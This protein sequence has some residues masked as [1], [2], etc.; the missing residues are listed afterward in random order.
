LRR[1]VA[2]LGSTGQ[3]G[4]DLVETLRQG[5]RFDVI[6]LSHGDADCR[7]ATRIHSVLAKFR[8]NVVINCAAFVRVDDCEDQASLA[9]EV[10][11]IGALNVARACAAIDAYCVY[12]STDYVFDG[13]KNTPYV[14]SDIPNPINVYGASKLAGEYLVRQAARRW[15]IVRVA[16]LFGKTGAR[17]KGGNF[18]EMILTKARR[19]EALKVIDDI[20]VSP[21]YTRDA[22]TAL[23]A[24]LDGRYEGIFH[25]SN[26]GQCTWYGFAERILELTHLGASLTPIRSEEYPIK[27]RRPRNSSLRSARA[28]IVSRPWVEALEAYLEERGHL[29]GHRQVSL[30]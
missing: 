23:A 3:L 7:K 27:A 13:V 8:P 14:E 9:F 16:S 11:A 2:V 21:T 5:D 6:A 17:G 1:R 22:A 29:K 19:G 28:E 26:S 25:L 4:T 10:N 20:C 18:I 15:L 24:L 30:H 12:I